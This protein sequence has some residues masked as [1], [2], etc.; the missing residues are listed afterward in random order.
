MREPPHTFEA[1]QALLGAILVDNAAF[2]A[3]GEIVAAAHFADPLHGRIY[4]SLRELIESGQHVNVVTLK[5]WIERDVDVAI[6]GGAKYL[7]RL[8]A[9]SVH[10][11][12]AVQAARQV[13]DLYRRRKLIQMAEE[14]ITRAYAPS[15][16]DDAQRQIETIERQLFELGDGA[17]AAG[18]DGFKSAETVIEETMRLA[19]AAYANASE[20][21]GLSTGFAS[22][23][24]ALGGLHPGELVILAGRPAMGK[25]ALATNIAVSA[26]DSAAGADRAPPVVGMFSLEMSGES[27]MTRILAERCGVAS[28]RLRRGQLHSVEFDRF[29]DAGHNFSGYLFIDDTPLLTIASL[30]A[31]AR[32]LK[33]QHGLGLL[34]VDYLQLLQGT[35]ERSTRLEQISEISRGLKAIAKEFNVP[36]LAL[37]QLSRAVES[38]DDKRPQL[39]DLRESGSIE[40]DADVVMFIYR[41]EYYLS[42]AEPKRRGDE[43]DDKF[44]TRCEAWSNAMQQCSGRAEV[45]IAKHRHGPTSSVA[46]TFDAA[47]SKF[48]DPTHEDWR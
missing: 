31:R 23:D 46:L 8:A 30:R 29:L 22:L 39:S 4:E 34:V 24:G 33:R 26:A 2:H 9:A 21:S 5:S 27:V 17:A 42:R 11:L 35:S 13:R 7:A 40:Q 1:E 6:V 15:I 48:A 44:N 10:A 12:D 43:S 19:E 14:A 45:I 16:A 38:R 32:R 37:S 18:N 25:T 47:L 28:Q 20:V 3:V 36:V 41:D